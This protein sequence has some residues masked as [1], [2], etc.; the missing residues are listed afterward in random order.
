MPKPGLEAWVVFLRSKWLHRIGGVPRC[1]NE[2]CHST[3]KAQR[4]FRVL[5]CTSS[6]VRSFVK[7]TCQ[8]VWNV[9]SSQKGM[10]CHLWPWQQMRF[11]L[12]FLKIIDCSK[13]TKGKLESESV[14]FL[15]HPLSVSYWSQSV[16]DLWLL[17]LRICLLFCAQ[18]NW[19]VFPFHPKWSK[20][21]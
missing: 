21:K 9:F 15:W 12:P 19:T 17:Y 6:T 10:S 14:K 2:T 5:N 11:D 18:I 13:V 7:H 8:S 3:P 4:H 1:H 16:E 20:C